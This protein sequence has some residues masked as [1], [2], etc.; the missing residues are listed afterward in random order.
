MLPSVIRLPMDE[1]KGGGLRGRQGGGEK[2]KREAARF[3]F[4]LSL[5]ER[6]SRP[7]EYPRWFLDH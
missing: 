3:F 2:K 7:T 5:L 6:A 4:F 1:Q